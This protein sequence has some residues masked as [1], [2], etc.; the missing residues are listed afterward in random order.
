[1]YSTNADGLWS[2]DQSLQV[3]I[4]SRYISCIF[5]YMPA[6]YSFKLINVS[7]MTSGQLA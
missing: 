3:F 4:N 6:V 5:T 7:S 2:R 1:M